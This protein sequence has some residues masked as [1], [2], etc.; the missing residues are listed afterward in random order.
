MPLYPTRFLLTLSLSLALVGCQANRSTPVRRAPVEPAV[1]AQQAAA[2]QALVNEGTVLSEQ[3][4]NEEALD[5]FSQALQQNPKLT[6]AHLGIGTVYRTQGEYDRAA[7]A[8]RSA[9]FTDPNNFDARY[10]YGLT[11][12]L[13]GLTEA[14]IAS[15]Q[16][17][18]LL[19]PNSFPANRDMGSAQLQHGDP[20]A[21]IPYAQRATELDPESQ[22]AWANLAAAYSLVGDYT[23]AIEAFRQTLELGEPAEPILLGLADAHIQLGNYQRAENVLRATLRTESGPIGYERLGFVLFRQARFED[24]L[25]AYMEAL[26]HEPQDLASLNGAGVC[27]MAM[28]LEGGE[29][30]DDLRARALAKWR[31]SLAIDRSQSMIIDLIARYSKE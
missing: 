2:A 26:K 4:N 28:Y 21:A 9:I 22:A 12:Q 29:Y 19:R 13:E 24:A 16:R 5:A 7:A 6:A 25:S 17:A 10:F 23:G 18:L 31:A 8:Y 11:N 3:G 30:D 14:A 27:L 1:S 20:H 15:Y